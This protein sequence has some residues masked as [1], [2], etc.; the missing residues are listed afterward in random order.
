VETQ[1]E[2]DR[3]LPPYDNWQR[4]LGRFARFVL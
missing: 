3:L 4:R 2:M 1:K